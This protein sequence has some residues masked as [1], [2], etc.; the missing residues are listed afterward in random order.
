MHIVQLTDLHVRPHGVPA[1]RVVETNLLTARALRA[2][3]RLDIRPD[4]IL[5]TGDL[6]DCGL[7]TEYHELAAL[8]RDNLPPGAPAVYAIPG[9]HDRREAMMAHLPGTRHNDGFVQYVVEDLPVRIIMLDTVAP[10]F[11]HGELCPRRLDWLDATLGAAPGRP[12]VVAMHHP[13][14]ACGIAHMDAINL[15]QSDAFAAIIARHPQVE[16]ILCGHHHR[17]ITARVAHT[18]AQIGPSVAH[19][20]EF[21][22]ASNAPSAF[23]MEPAAFMVHRWSTETSMV[24]HL[25]YVEPFPGPYPF[26]SEPDYPGRGGR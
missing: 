14:F 19:Q 25:A 1:Y 9:N 22:L 11:G 10:G 18:I 24:S 7:Q 21:A 23:V 2:V 17:P 15:R 5:I 12:T 26:L 13:P 16:R 20:V 4:V 8:L 6:T 3:M